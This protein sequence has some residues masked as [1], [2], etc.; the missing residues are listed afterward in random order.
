MARATGAKAV[1]T[2]LVELVA[3]LNG[4]AFR[5]INRELRSNA[6]DIAR[7]LESDVSAAVRKS[8]A[9]QAEKMA[10][11]VR[12]VRDRVPVVAIGRT[13]PKLSGFK[14]RRRARDASGDLVGS[15]T[16][17][18]RGAVAH[19]VVYGPLGGHR[20]TAR[21]ENYYRIT[22]DSS[23]GPVGRAMG[24]SGS[25]FQAACQQ[26]LQAYRYVLARHGFSTGDPARWEG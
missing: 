24:P 18:N 20:A 2:G 8:R 23:G 3:A 13:V 26:Y 19:G 10:P 12:A 7:E 17:R 1:T 21:H 22:R 25:V 11:T 6:L 9:P 4:P 15:D 16:K 5:G 14:R